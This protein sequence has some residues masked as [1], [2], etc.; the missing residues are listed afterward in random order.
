M[1]V[2]YLV[3]IVNVALLF[4]QDHFSKEVKNM[5]HIGQETILQFLVSYRV[6]SGK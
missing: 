3:T 1:K 2:C 4:W 6:Q 5:V